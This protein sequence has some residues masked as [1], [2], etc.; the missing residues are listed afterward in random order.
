MQLVDITIFMYKVKHR[1]LPSNI[2]D[3]FSGTPSGYNLRNSDFHISGFYS[4][5]YRKH[6]LRY[7]GPKLW[8]KLGHS[9]RQMP[10]LTSCLKHLQKRPCE[11]SFKLC[12]YRKLCEVCYSG[13]VLLPLGLW[14][15]KVTVL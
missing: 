1:L 8:S 7:P 4:V 10:T 11:P 9:N 3:L 13:V 15:G 12:L 14:T 5:H 6:S 2:L